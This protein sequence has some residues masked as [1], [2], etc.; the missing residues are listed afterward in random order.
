MTAAR[1]AIAIVL[2]SAPGFAQY[3][4]TGEWGARYHEDFAERIPGPELGDY[5]G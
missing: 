2:L 1:L 4:L 3:D 5:L